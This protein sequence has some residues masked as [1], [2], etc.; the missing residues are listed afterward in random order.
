M[1]QSFNF[2]KHVT[3]LLLYFA[4]FSSCIIDN[5][6]FIGKVENKSDV[7]ISIV[8]S[9]EHLFSDSLLSLSLGEYYVGKRSLNSLTISHLP[10][11]EITHVWHFYI[12]N[13]DSLKNYSNK[14]EF[15]RDYSS[16]TLKKCYLGEFSIT[17]KE[18]IEKKI[19]ICYK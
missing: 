11:K 12:F 19:S 4:F 2:Y 10:K 6:N 9:D 18:L 1:K 7:N 3:F 14:S 17:Q 16:E 5:F 15:N 13:A 8:L